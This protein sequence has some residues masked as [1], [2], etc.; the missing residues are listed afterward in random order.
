MRK[1]HFLRKKMIFALA[2]VFMFSVLMAGCKQARANEVENTGTNPEETTQ[3][4]SDVT[5]D[6]GWLD[7]D[8]DLWLPEDADAE[9]DDSADEEQTSDSE[10]Q[11]E[12][13]VYGPENPYEGENPYQRFQEDKSSSED[14]SSLETEASSQNNAKITVQPKGADIRA[15]QT[16][17]FNVEAEGDGLRYQWQVRETPDKEW[18]NSRSSGYKTTS[19]S[20]DGRI[21]YNGFEFRCQV[22]DKYGNAVTSNPASLSVFAITKD[23]TEENVK[24]GKTA[25][26]IAGAVGKDVKFKWQQHKSSE[27]GWEDYNGSGSTDSTLKIKEASTDF[28]GYYFRCK[29]T[30]APGH[31]SYTKAAPMYVLGIRKQPSEQNISNGGSASFSVSAT[32]KN[33][34]YQWKIKRAGEDEWKNA[35]GSGSQT[36][37]V[38]FS[39]VGVG[40]NNAKLRCKITDAKGTHIYSDTVKLYV[41]GISSNPHT[42]YVKK[43]THVI[44]EVKAAGK[45]LEYQWWQKKASD[46]DWYQASG[47]GARTSKLDLGAVS[48]KLNGMRYRCQVYDSEGRDEI[49]KTA[50]LYVLAITKNPSTQNVESGTQAVFNVSASGAGLK[51]SWQVKESSSDEWRESTSSGHNTKTLKVNAG[52]SRNGYRFRCKV[53]DEKGNVVYSNPA[54]LYVPGIL[55]NPTMQRVKSGATA[56]FR[57]TAT[58]QGL[59]YSWEVNE[60]HGGGWRSSS[61]P[62]HLTNTLKVT[63]KVGFN[64]YKFRCKV[65]DSKGRTFYSKAATLYVLGIRSQPSDREVDEGKTVSFHVTA[66]GSGVRYQWQI[67]TKGASWRNS[68]STGNKSSTV[69]I[70]ATAGLNGA[71]IRCRLKDGAGNVIYT[72][73]AKLKV[74]YYNFN[75]VPH[76]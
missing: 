27:S 72:R 3:S 37:E 21:E 38:K 20:V 9:F 65:R 11:G 24:K 53:S 61:S 30:D 70:K 6:D 43:D 41:F 5:D 35:G 8:A 23:P 2:F 44:F 12:D 31:T 4:Q 36:P 10:E 54:V 67:K 28:N 14:S 62:G 68:S 52:I 29:V 1:S 26:F 75:Y 48:P 18:R 49:S 76:R 19:L 22:T 33:I 34:K 47:S 7:D 66:A 50:V 59:K 32:G 60:G 69:K 17:V 25:T 13:T 58:G 64:G 74:N 45:D 51:Y 56:T 57:V 55:K 46:D 42:K 73:E 39:G 15:G 71:L 40:A 16:A 63:G